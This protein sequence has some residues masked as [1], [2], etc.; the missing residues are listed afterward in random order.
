V[1][2][3]VSQGRHDVPTEKL[4]TRSPRIMANLKKAL[5]ELHHV[6]VFDNDDL[7]SSYRLVAVYEAGQPVQV[8]KPVPRRLKAAFS[9]P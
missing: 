8:H 2:L 4:E 1:A 9:Q 7:G 6:W 3:H 5:R